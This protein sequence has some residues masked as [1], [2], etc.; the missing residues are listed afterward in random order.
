[1]IGAIMINATI[2]PFSV[3]VCLAAGAGLIDA[4]DA[5]EI[6]RWVGADGIVHYSDEKP[7]DEDRIWETLEVADTRPQDYDPLTDPYSIQN[8]ARRINES[9]TALAQARAERIEDRRT[10]SQRDTA[11]TATSEFGPRIEYGTRFYSPWYYPPLAR[12][13]LRRR[14]D[15]QPGQQQLQAING[16]NLASPR[17]ASINSGVHRDRVLRSESLPTATRRPAR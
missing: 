10:A 7:R 12:R 11:R 14:F 2:R 3:L 8:Q 17:P 4:A 5:A 15:A 13:Y 1:M 9:W 16:L 6:Y